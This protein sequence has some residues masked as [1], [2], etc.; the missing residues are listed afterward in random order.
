MPLLGMG[1]GRGGFAF[2]EV[3]VLST[4]DAYSAIQTANIADAGQ[5]EWA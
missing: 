4:K 3:I 1:I 5:K 2:W